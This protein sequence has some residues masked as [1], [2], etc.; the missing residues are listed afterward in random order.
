MQHYE[1]TDKKLK[2]TVLL[3]GTF[4][5]TLHD[6][7]FIDEI[8]KFYLMKT[9]FWFMKTIV[10]LSHNAWKYHAISLHENIMQHIMQ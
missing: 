5:N 9:W 1:Y 8:S 6:I 4:L 7:Y 10:L 2:S 3:K